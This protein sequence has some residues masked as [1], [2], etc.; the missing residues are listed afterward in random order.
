MRIAGEHEGPYQ[1]RTR[2]LDINQMI[3][4]CKLVNATHSYDINT[5]EVSSLLLYLKSFWTL[6]EYHD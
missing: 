4:M 5:A 1:F 2:L 3:V 6:L